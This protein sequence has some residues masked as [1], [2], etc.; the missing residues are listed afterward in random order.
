MDKHG[1][2]EEYEEYED[3]DQEEEADKTKSAKSFIVLTDSPEKEL[4]SK[5]S[6]GLALFRKKKVRPWFEEILQG[7]KKF[8]YLFIGGKL[9]F[10]GGEKYFSPYKNFSLSF[11]FL[12]GKKLAVEK[13]F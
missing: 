12:G 3:T 8:S 10:W 1:K 7:I 11:N 13:N 9:K 5:S 2:V 4:E 6:G